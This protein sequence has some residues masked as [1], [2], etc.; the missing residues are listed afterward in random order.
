METLA[1]F[2]AFN[3]LFKLFSTFNHCPQDIQMTDEGF[4]LPL[5]PGDA[6]VAI[7]DWKG[8][9]RWLSNHTIKTGVG[10]LGWSNMVD[11]SAERFK[12][13]F[14]RTATL[15]ER[16]SLEI[17][18]KNGLRYKIWMWSVGNPD[19]AVCTFNWLI[20]S[21]IELLTV[22]ERE[23]MEELGKGTALKQIAESLDVSVNTLHAHVRNIKNKLKLKNTSEVVSFA[24]RFFL[25]NTESFGAHCETSTGDRDPPA[26]R[27]NRRTIF[28]KPAGDGARKR[29]KS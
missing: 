29:R 23:L 11:E 20:P 24:S 22:R 4:E 12:E 26:A 18:S 9:V 25:K 8:V 13:A 21:E 27:R 3:P 7:C 1:F 28:G 19:L 5:S 10:D 6:F 15:H 14:A 17:S 16:R 2:K